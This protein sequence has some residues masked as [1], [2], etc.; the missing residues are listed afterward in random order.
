MDPEMADEQPA[1]E[2]HGPA[3]VDP[4]VVDLTVVDPPVVESAVVEPAADDPAAADTAAEPASPEGVFSLRDNR[5]LQAAVAVGVVALLV[6]V[7]L[8]IQRPGSGTALAGTVSPEAASPA[9]QTAASGAASAS[10][11]ASAAAS[12]AAS[13]VPTIVATTAAAP[14]PFASTIAGIVSG[15][16][17]HG[18]VAVTDLTTGATD[19]YSDGG[20]LFDTGSIVKLDILATLFYQHQQDGTSMTE[21]EK[22]YAA[23]MIENSNNDSATALF[24]IDGDVSGL[25][26]ANRVFGLTGTTIDIDWG[27]TTTDPTEQMK[28]LEQVFTSDSVLS[29]A[30]R[31]YIQGLM[32]QVESDQRWGVSAAAS[33][34]AGYMLKNGWLP[35][36]ATGLWTIN[37]IGEVSD[38]GHLL[39]IAV[40]SDGNS[41]MNAGVAYIQQIAAAAAGS[42]IANENG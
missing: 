34:G 22:S 12:A 39:L 15:Q 21:S 16:S 18:A 32:S 10:A 20:H 13:A 40:Q 1:E 29:P 23:T 38:D 14:E 35:S 2:E 5:V 37:S 19:S 24:D 36:S 42:L 30:S 4:P 11:S 6:G 3:E 7:M 33:P 27:D 41:T 17:A 26:A 31:A 28:L 9:S 25:T 8:L